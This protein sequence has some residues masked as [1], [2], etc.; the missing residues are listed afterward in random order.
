MVGSI[1]STFD[2]VF[3]VG[4][5]ASEGTP[6]ALLAHTMYAGKVLEMKLNGLAIPEAVFSAATAGEFGVPV[7]FLSGDQSIAAQ[8]RA[9]LGPIETAV[10][11][12]ADGFFSG[13]MLHPEECQRLI[14]EGARRA[15]ERRKELKPYR[16]TRPVKLE[17]T[18]KKTVDAELVSY[19]HDV[20]RPRGN[21]AVFTGRDMADVSRF[22]SV[23]GYLDV[24]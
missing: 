12:T 9:L 11:K 7:V 8:A 19:L 22:V 20:E 1:D 23:I 15:L 18:F 2:A 14:R 5:H 10:V 17:I 6:G 21:V 13:T 4:Y 3:L 16:V 24:H